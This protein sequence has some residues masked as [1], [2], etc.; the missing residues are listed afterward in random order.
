[1]ANEKLA[2][3]KIRIGWFA[4]GFVGRPASG[5]AYVARRVV[6]HFIIRCS[7]K[8]ILSICRY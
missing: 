2:Y 3:K 6:E 5:T 1:M 7:D 8:F 4:S